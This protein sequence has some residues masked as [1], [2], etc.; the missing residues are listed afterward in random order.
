MVDRKKYEGIASRYVVYQNVVLPRLLTAK[1]EKT[2][3]DTIKN[4]SN[5][6]KTKAR[7]L[8]IESNLKLVINIAKY[9]ENLGVEF[10]DLIGEG[11][12]GL[13]TA[14][15]RFNPRKGARFSTYAGFWIRQRITRTLCNRSG[16]VRLPVY[17][18]Q[19]SLSIRK[20]EAAF[21]E[22]FGRSPTNK[23]ISKKYGMSEN[24][25]REMKDALR[26]VVHLDSTMLDNKGSDIGDF[27]EVIAD[28]SV[29]TAS[30]EAQLN[31]ENKCLYKLIDRLD[32]REQIVIK[33]RFGLLHHDCETLEAIGLKFNITRERIRQIEVLALKK[34][35]T[36]CERDRRI[37]I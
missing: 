12:I 20:Y 16:I 28:E 31:N 6:E 8:F 33:C 34:L 27:K 1:E 4:G 18:K 35:K 17:L 5:K 21:E 7:N 14:V 36:M 30:E 11:N 13:M 3:A 15:D 37:N 32:E 2:L 10:E 22:Q 23:E 9:Y 25:V 26:D 19:A 24:K 29:K